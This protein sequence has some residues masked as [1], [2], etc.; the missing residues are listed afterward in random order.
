MN[1]IDCVSSQQHKCPNCHS[2]KYVTLVSKEYCPDC[3]IECDY[4]GK[5]QNEAYQT[6]MREK[7]KREAIEREEEER[8]QR[9]EN[10]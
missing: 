4:W 2:S 1:I 8:R 6:F 5:G 3:K 10:W 7:Y 9:E